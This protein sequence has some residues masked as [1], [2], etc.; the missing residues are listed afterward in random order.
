MKRQIAIAG[1]TVLLLALTILAASPKADFSGTWVMDKTRTEGLPPDIEQTMT[2][3]QKDDR[4]DVVT[5]VSGDQGDQTVPV[6]YVLDGKETEYPANRMG[7]G[8]GKRTASWSADGNGFEV[9][10]EENY[11]TKNGPTKIQFSRKW[12]MAPDGKT[13]VIILDI[14]GPNGNGTIKRTFV[15]K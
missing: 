6:T 15:K 1:I 10:E 14:K 8:K 9:S 7:E 12:T 13:V 5:K 11:D 2:V 4:I 3:T